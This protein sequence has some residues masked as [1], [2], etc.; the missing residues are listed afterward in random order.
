[1]TGIEVEDEHKDTDLS[2]VRVRR[3]MER[4]GGNGKERGGE[5]QSEKGLERRRA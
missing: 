2:G 1:V 4:E 3:R 5:S